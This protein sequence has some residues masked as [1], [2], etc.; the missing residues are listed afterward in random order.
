MKKI[1]FTVALLSTIVLSAQTMAF[2]A[3]E[4]RV[5]EHTQKDIEEAFDKVFEGVEM[6]QGGVVLERIWNGRTNGMTHRLVWMYTLGVDLVDD[7]A[8]SPDRNDAFWAKMNNYIEKWGSGYSGRI[9]SWQEGDT[10]K[11]PAIHIWDI[12]VEN[13]NQFKKGHDKIVKEFK[14]D[15]AGR[16]VG[17]GTYDIGRPDGATHWVGVS[18]KNRVD[19]LMLLDKLQKSSKF[20]TLL[21]E[22]GKTEDVKDYELEILRR[23]Q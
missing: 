20:I 18:G 19:H 6:K 12:K 23:K 13:Q 2:T 5:K 3:V 17:F 14:D 9:L 16:V 4:V 15:F 10:T 11:N 1:M 8:I 7:D 22:R 21:Q